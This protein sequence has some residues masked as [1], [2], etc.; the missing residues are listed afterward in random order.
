MEKGK[1][2]IAQERML[3]GAERETHDC[4]SSED[5]GL[6]AQNVFSERGF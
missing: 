5:G 1:W 4:E 6:R 2:K 3:I